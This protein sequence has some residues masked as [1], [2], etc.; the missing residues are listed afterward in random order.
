MVMMILVTV[1][2]PYVNVYLKKKKK[3]QCMNF[4]TRGLDADMYAV[5]EVRTITDLD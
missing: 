2:S 3:H 4:Y 5:I 1:C